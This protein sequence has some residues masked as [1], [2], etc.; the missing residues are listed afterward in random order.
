M[1]EDDIREAVND[2]ECPLTYAELV[3]LLLAP[4]GPSLHRL[5]DELEQQAAGESKSDS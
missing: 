5:L 2:P 3:D 4:R 1:S